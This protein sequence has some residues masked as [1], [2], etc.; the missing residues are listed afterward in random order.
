[1]R[2]GRGWAGRAEHVAPGMRRGQRSRAS[3]DVVAED[4]AHRAPARA[5]EEE[6]RRA[7][8]HSLRDE[9]ERVGA[10]DARAAVVDVRAQPLG[11]RAAAGAAVAARARAGGAV[12]EAEL[13]YRCRLVV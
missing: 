12:A 10:D 4:G 7:R 8:R 3:F 5:L 9:R 11:V 1:M 13:V 6:A 2:L